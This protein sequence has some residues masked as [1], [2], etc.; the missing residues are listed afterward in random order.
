MM[1]SE[2]LKRIVRILSVSAW[3]VL[4]LATALSIFQL[5]LPPTVEGVFAGGVV[6]FVLVQGLAWTLA[7]YSG[8]PK[9]ADGLISWQ[10]FRQARAP[11]IDPTPPEA[12]PEPSGVGGLL[13][14]PIVGFTALGPLAAVSQTLRYLTEAE[15][16][17]PAL[18]K[19]SAWSTYK[20]AG[21][22]LIA[23]ACV[24][25]ITAGYRLVVDHRPQSVRFAIWV[26]WLRGP[27]MVVA[28][29]ALV[30]IFLNLKPSAYFGDAQTVSAF[31]GSILIS[32]LWT[33][34]FKCSRRVLNTYRSSPDSHAMSRNQ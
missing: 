3:A 5:A 15:N 18:L 13:W 24:L 7:R 10:M 2:G 33:L 8:N 23:V 32:L 14:L 22:S 4:G 28:D 21:W 20:M 25:S 26:L 6:F 34:Y 11:A 1:S 27:M 9:G 29:A 16:L 19:A 31:I 30:S 17:Y 12:R